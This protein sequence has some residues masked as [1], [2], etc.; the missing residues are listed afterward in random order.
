MQAVV[1][2]EALIVGRFGFR[3]VVKVILVVLTSD[4]KRKVQNA[5]EV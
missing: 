2:A 5:R 4:K 1:V 3:E